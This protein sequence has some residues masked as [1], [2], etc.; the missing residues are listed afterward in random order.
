MASPECIGKKVLISG[1]TPVDPEN[2]VAP[3]AIN[4]CEVT[5]EEFLAYEAKRFGSKYES[6]KDLP[7]IEGKFAGPRK[8]MINRNWQ[9]A[10]DYCLAQGGDLPTGEQWEK[11]ARGPQGKTYAIQGDGK[12]LKPK[13]ANY[14]NDQSPHATTDVGSY[15]P[16]D[17][18]LYDIT[19]N[20]WEWVLDK[21]GFGSRSLRG[22]SWSHGNEWGLRA[23]YN[24]YVN[25][26]ARIN[27][28]GLRCVFPPGTP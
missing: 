24:D 14:W 28:I 18:G 4:A 5:Q 8:P 16:N 9:E 13:L 20:V 26:G 15:P 12:K 19:G 10:R 25:P 22:G 3:F 7:K 21:Y 11:A 23:D 27:L 17:N 1:A 6:A 2:K